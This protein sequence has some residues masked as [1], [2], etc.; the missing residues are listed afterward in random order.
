M[1]LITKSMT[2]LR[3]KIEVGIPGKRKGDAS[4]HDKGIQRFF[5]QVMEA[6]QR[7][8]NFQVIKAVVIASPGFTKDAFSTY[9]WDAAQKHNQ[10]EFIDNRTKFIL[11]HSSSGHKHALNE[12]LENK[13][14]AAKLV[15]TRSAQEAKALQDFYEHLMKDTY[16]ACYGLKHVKYANEAFAIDT[17]LITDELFRASS[18]ATRKAYVALVESVREN[19]G[20]VL[21]FSVNHVTGEELQRHTGI[22][23]ILRQPLF[24]L[25][26]ISG[27]EV[28]AIPL[29][30]PA[31]AAA[32][33]EQ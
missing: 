13:E 14:V 7:H 27:D 28:E 31:A 10:R 17:L 29:T 18:L 23:A 6:M 25:D 15:D 5:Q 21:I 19:N 2:L 26:D 8:F 30:L 33:S 22:A 1:C 3:Q 16:R 20:T 11:A 24:E 9:L 32:S 12:V 4:K